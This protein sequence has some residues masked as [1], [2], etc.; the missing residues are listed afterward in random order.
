MANY[1]SIP[2]SG[3]VIQRHI[4]GDLNPQQSS[5]LLNEDA[6]TKT[7]EGPIIMWHNY[8][9]FAWKTEEDSHISLAG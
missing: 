7:S 3:M 9:E 8:P 4:P 5:K 2:P 1:I 6:S